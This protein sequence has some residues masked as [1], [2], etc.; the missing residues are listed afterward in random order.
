MTTSAFAH[1]GSEDGDFIGVGSVS[2]DTDSSHVDSLMSCGLSIPTQTHNDPA[3]ANYWRAIG[4]QLSGGFLCVSGTLWTNAS[5]GSFSGIGR[6]A[7]FLLRFLDVGGVPRL[8]L[9]WANTSGNGGP[10]GPFAVVKIDMAGNATQLGASFSGIQANVK[11][12]ISLLADFTGTVQVRVNGAL[13]YNYSGT[14]ATD[15]GNAFGGY[16]L[17]PAATPSTSG[18]GTTV[19]SGVVAAHFDCSSI[20]LVKL[21]LTGAGAV[22]DWNGASDGSTVREV[23][24]DITNG[25]DSAAPNQT[26]LFGASG[27][28][29]SGNWAI[30]G[31]G[32]ATLASASPFGPALATSAGTSS[33]NVL[34]FS[35]TTGISDGMSLSGTNIHSD[36]HVVSFVANTSVTIDNAVTGTISSGDTIDFKIPQHMQIGVRL[37]GTTYLSPTLLQGA[38]GTEALGASLDRV[39]YVFDNSPAT[40]QLFSSSEIGTIEIGVKSIA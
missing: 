31:V 34:H 32:I 7:S 30:V 8:A 1:W 35:D 12:R 11:Q 40:G 28:L 25:I 6:G 39:A 3:I 14:F 29:P 10:T 36:S 27:T 17:G 9:T 21:N 20:N 4:E 22:S 23:P 15:G 2:I 18:A 19:W 37:G 26:E 33:G 16:D 24:M 5:G 38:T 13:L